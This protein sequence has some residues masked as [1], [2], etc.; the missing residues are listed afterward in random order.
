VEHDPG[1]AAVHLINNGFGPV[2]HRL[3]AAR[4]VLEPQGIMAVVAPASERE[5]C[6]GVAGD[7]VIPDRPPDGFN[8][9]RRC[10]FLS[11]IGDG[12]RKQAKGEGQKCDKRI[13]GR[14]PFELPV[15]SPKSD[16]DQSAEPKADGFKSAAEILVGGGL[17]QLARGKEMRPVR[18]R[19]KRCSVSMVR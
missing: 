15:G 16:V 9:A 6:D 3:L 14:S 7:L 11:S 2:V 8:A 4:D 1:C 18:D 17:F 13:H 5:R 10:G 19:R 12:W